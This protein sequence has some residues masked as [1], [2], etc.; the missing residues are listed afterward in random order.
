M[1]PLALTWSKITC[2]LPR[3]CPVTGWPAPPGGMIARI[4]KDNL[5]A[6]RIDEPDADMNLCDLYV[7]S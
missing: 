4:M 3:S 7:P 1:L 6:G 5:I 2:P